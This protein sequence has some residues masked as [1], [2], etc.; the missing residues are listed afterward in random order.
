MKDGATSSYKDRAMSSYPTSVIPSSRVSQVDE[1]QFFRVN[2]LV[3]SRLMS[4][5]LVTWVI[6]RLY[7]DV[8]IMHWIEFIV[9]LS[10]NALEKECLS[11]TLEL[12]KWGFS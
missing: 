5:N 3:T 8:W 4:S 12:G 2:L 1:R 6:W 11:Y 7:G 10:P 9:A